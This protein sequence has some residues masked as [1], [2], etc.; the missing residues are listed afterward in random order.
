MADNKAGVYMA[1]DPLEENSRWTCNLCGGSR[2][3]SEINNVLEDIGKELVD[4][5][6]ESIEACE[7]FLHKYHTILHPNHFYLTY[8]RAQKAISSN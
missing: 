4:L 1:D 6:R 5:K 3:S 7:Q 2:S 8:Y